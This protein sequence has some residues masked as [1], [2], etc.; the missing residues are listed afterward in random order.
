MAMTIDSRNW[1]GNL[2]AIGARPLKD[3]VVPGSHDAGTYVMYHD[4]DTKSSQCQ[5]VNIVEQLR[6]GSRYLDLRAWKSGGTYWMYHGLAWTS[7][8]LEDVLQQ[9]L[10]FLNESPKEIVIATL[11]IKDG[12]NWDE[13][14]WAW[15]CQ[16]VKTQ[17]ASRV[18]SPSFAMVTPNDLRQSTRRLVLLKHE[19]APGQGDFADID[20]D[21]VYA[22]TLS[23]QD[24]LEQL[25]AFRV[26]NNKMWILHM[27]LPFSGS[28]IAAAILSGGLSYLVGVSLEDKAKQA[29]Q[30]FLPRFRRWQRRRLN[31]INVDFVDEFGWVEAIVKLNETYPKTWPLYFGGEGGEPFADPQA[32][33]ERGPITRIEVRHGVW[34]DALRFTYGSSAGRWHGGTGGKLDT[35]KVPEGHKIVRVEGRSGLYIDQLQFFTDKG[36]RSKL[37][38][39]PGGERFQIHADQMILGNSLLTVTG[40]ASQY[41]D[42][43]TFHYNDYSQEGYQVG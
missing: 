22:G 5:R 24:T 31:V 37:F 9:I 8:K 30:F 6:A 25:R 41:V 16:K 23:P 36:D 18:P 42:G 27:G 17:L 3:I 10:T 19:E 40:R 7:V 39:G 29:A 14:G 1:M 4:A 34:I 13:D 38:G 15:A 32:L 28:E 21:G 26:P 11:L 43:L 12:G 33:L 20:R 2:S 35:Y